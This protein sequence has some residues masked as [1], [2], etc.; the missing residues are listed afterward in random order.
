MKHLHLAACSL[1]MMST[2]QILKKLFQK[3]SNTKELYLPF[4]NQDDPDSKKQNLNP[5][6]FQIMP[7]YHFQK[8]CQ[9]LC[10][11]TR[12]YDL[13]TSPAPHETRTLTQRHAKRIAW[14]NGEGYE[15][16]FEQYIHRISFSW[17]TTKKQHIT[18]RLGSTAWS[19]FKNERYV[20]YNNKPSR[21]SSAILLL[22]S[23][24]T[25]VLSFR[26]YNRIEIR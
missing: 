26:A 10:K 15:D 8:S 23:Q 16:R 22:V 4:K 2:V 18:G 9:A 7:G 12:D 25:S 1:F 19:L 3:P 5:R 17:Y 13:S 11:T 14:E 20:S 24:R 21:P 6:L